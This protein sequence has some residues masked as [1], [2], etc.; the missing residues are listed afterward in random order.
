[1]KFLRYYYNDEISYG[2]LKKDC[3][4]T[5]IKIKGS[6]FNEFEELSEELKIKD[7]KLLTPCDFTK[8]V[9]VG[10]NY[11]DHIIEFNHPIPESPVLFIKPSNTAI[12]IHE[13]IIKPQLCERLDYEAELAIVIGSKTHNIEEKDAHKYILG[14]TCANDVT[15]RDLQPQK[16]QWTLAK[17]FDTFCPF[18]PF[19]E[20]EINPTNLNIK[21]ILNGKVMQESNTS[22]LI[23]NPFYLVSYISK[24]MTL[25]PGD[26][27][28]T[29]TPSGVSHMKD[30]STISIKIEGIGTLTNTVE[31]QQ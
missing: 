30:L 11:R 25:Y 12:G 20:T 3:E 2:I 24:I 16:G 27:I 9:C 21:S 13:N 19:I 17:S 4:D 5:I 10:L 8:A 28:L 23:F 22:N 18:G 7:V 26:I 31:Y 14:Y 15:A 6:P 1:M 29:G